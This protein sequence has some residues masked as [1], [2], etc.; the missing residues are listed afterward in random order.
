MYKVASLFAG[1]G[2]FALAFRRQ[3]FQSI[4][5]NENDKFAA[6]TY[7]C[8]NSDSQ[9]YE[10]DVEE[11]HP[12]ELGLEVPDVLTAGFPCQPFSSAGDRLGFED[13]R[14]H[15]YKEIVRILNEF[16]S[17][18]PRIV[19]LENVA[20]LLGH[21]GGRTYARIEAELKGAGY[22]VLPHNVARLNTRIHTESP[23]NR[24][25]LFIVA[26]STAYFKGGRFHFPT[27]TTSTLDV[28]E[29]LQLSCPADEYYYFDTTNNRYGQMLMRSAT[30][31]NPG[32][33]YQLRRSYVREYKSF[34]PTLTANMGDGGHNVPVVLD[35]WGLR[36]LTP[37]ECARF[38][39]FVGAGASF[40]DEVSR[41]QRYKQIGNSVTV[42]L[43]EKLAVECMSLLT[44]PSIRKRTS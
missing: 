16:G 12:K 36:Q 24:E 31:G 7:R 22:W 18:R 39:G 38:Q 4:W 37:E 27:A 32:S 20:N 41:V 44:D 42:P 43:V 13:D 25:R 10:C 6:A 14:G 11:F 21:D 30:K 5:A 3:G 2:G 23:Q 8:N 9:L 19:L 29:L 40:P 33:V 28:R 26:L 17:D 1:L 34:L 35:N 15:L